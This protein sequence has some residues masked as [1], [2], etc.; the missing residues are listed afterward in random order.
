MFYVAYE[1]LSGCPGC[2]EVSYH[3]CRNIASFTPCELGL[4]RVRVCFV[5]VCFPC[6]YVLYVCVCVFVLFVLA[7]LCVLLIP[8]SSSVYIYLYI[9][10]IYPERWLYMYGAGILCLYPERWLYMYGAGILCLCPER[11]GK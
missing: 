4:P 1:S 8:S 7:V 9:L 5:C 3:E 6:L 11:W 10:S 2:F